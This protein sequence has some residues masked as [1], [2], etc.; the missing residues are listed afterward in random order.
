MGYVYL[1]QEIDTNNFK[2]GV[3]RQLIETRRKQL[4]TGNSNEIDIISHYQCDLPFKLE[5][6]LHNFYKKFNVNGEWF[7]L[8]DDKVN[9]VDEFQ[10]LCEKYNNI[11]NVLNTHNPFF[12]KKNQH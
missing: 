10:S 8:E 6:M 5:S 7:L 2:I 9:I 1:M 11:I 4:Q 12:N 3:T